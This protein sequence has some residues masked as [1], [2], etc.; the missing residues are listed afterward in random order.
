MMEGNRHT[1]KP[2]A[3]EDDDATLS[4]DDFA[5]FDRTTN[6]PSLLVLKQVFISSYNKATRENNKMDQQANDATQ[7][8]DDKT[9]QS[10][11]PMQK[12]LNIT[13]MMKQASTSAQNQPFPTTKQHNTRTS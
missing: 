4:V 8:K 6:D 10:N 1:N 11:N 3:M 12:K 5:L 2:K 7:P 9:Q 13:T